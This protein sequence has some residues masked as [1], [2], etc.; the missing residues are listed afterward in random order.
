MDELQLD[1]V[2]EMLD[3]IDD[4]LE[5]IAG[6]LEGLARREAGARPEAVGVGLPLMARATS[7]GAELEQREVQDGS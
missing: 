6:A 2:V 4:R 3:R 1:P 5:R 7:D